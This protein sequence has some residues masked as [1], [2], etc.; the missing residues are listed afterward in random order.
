MSFSEG[1]GLGRVHGNK[2]EKPSGRTILIGE[3]LRNAEGARRIKDGAL[4]IFSSIRVFL[5]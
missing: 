2:K 5:E 3:G 4:Y 1:K